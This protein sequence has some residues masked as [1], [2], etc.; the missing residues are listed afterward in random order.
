[1]LDMG[2]EIISPTNTTAKSLCGR[3]TVRSINGY[4][5]FNT[6]GVRII[7]AT[8]M[9]LIFLGLCI[10]TIGGLVQKLHHARLSWATDG[11]LQ[12]QRMAYEGA[13]YGPWEDCSSNQPVIGDFQG[14]N[15]GAR[16]L[17]YPRHST[18]STHEAISVTYPIISPQLVGKQ[19]RSKRHCRALCRQ[20]VDPNIVQWLDAMTWY[21]ASPFLY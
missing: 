6:L 16:W 2:G 10:D 1:M 17:G 18:P 9:V 5:N 7:L 8:T 14:S 13:G 15:S 11:Y 4:Q 12:L 20:Y 3:Q 21:A 19:Y